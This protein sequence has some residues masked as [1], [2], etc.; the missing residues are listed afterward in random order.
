MKY[1]F[2]LYSFSHTILA[3]NVTG[4]SMNVTGLEVKGNALPYIRFTSWDK[5][6]RHFLELGAKQELL[7]AI[8]VSLRKTSLAVLTI[9]DPPSPPPLRTSMRELEARSVFKR[10]K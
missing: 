1:R 6:V 7:D 5:A 4:L 9:T 3:V 10:G 8:D 2:I